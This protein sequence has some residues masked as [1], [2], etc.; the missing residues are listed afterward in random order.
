MVKDDGRNN[1]ELAYWLALTRIPAI[2]NL[3][4]H[5]L[6]IET[7]SPEAIFA[8]DSQSLRGFGVKRKAIEYIRAPDRDRIKADLDW[9]E[10]PLNHLLT[11]DSPCYPDL[12]REISDPP[13]ALFVRGK[14]ELLNDLQIAIVGA[15]KP[16]RDG[17]RLAEEFAAQLVKCGITITSGLAMGID[18]C[19]HRG[20]LFE[21]GGTVAVLG[22]GLDMIYPA[23][24][25]KL[26][27][28]IS[29]IGALVSEY[30]LGYRPRPANFPLRNRIISGL[31][32][33]VLVVE[34]AA[35]SGSLITARHAIEQ[36]REVFALPGSIRNPMSEGCHALIRDGAT[37]VSGVPHILE[38][39]GS[40]ANF[41]P[42]LGSNE[43]KCTDLING[44]DA[45]AKLLLDNIAY[46]PISVDELVEITNL[47]INVMS[48][49]L[50]KLEMVSL[51]ESIPGGNYR[52]R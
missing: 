6:L 46:E 44:L 50:L 31:S 48:T 15:R 36:G 29:Q 7:G 11:F 51:V 4:L 13:V 34:A 19:A 1:R 18:T 43:D 39:I 41:A 47:P 38:E 20:V 21:D 17:C 16:T 8:L 30:P 26:S 2:S 35:I 24:N 23:S 45:E 32:L 3:L 33:G 12:L 14:V 28:S 9:L 25:R 10:D 42:E 5:Q 27:E 22:H 49:E 40:L 37:L 52:R